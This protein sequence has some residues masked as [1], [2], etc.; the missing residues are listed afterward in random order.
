MLEVEDQ[1]DDDSADDEAADC[2][3]DDVAD[4]RAG[5]SVVRFLSGR[6]RIARRSSRFSRFGR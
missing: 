6:G 5:E 2:R 3:A 4:L 1:A